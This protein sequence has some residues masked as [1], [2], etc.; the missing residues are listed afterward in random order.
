MTRAIQSEQRSCQ[1]SQS[2]HVS[3]DR[4]FSLGVFIKICVQ[5]DVRHSDA[6]TRDDVDIPRDANTPYCVPACPKTFSRSPVPRSLAHRLKPVFGR[7][8][9]HQRSQ[10]LISPQLERYIIKSHR[11]DRRPLALKAGGDGGEPVACVSGVHGVSQG[12]LGDIL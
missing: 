2:K 6:F 1:R 10:P 7:L 3:L 5:L 8:L 12:S 4:S 11:I 9:R